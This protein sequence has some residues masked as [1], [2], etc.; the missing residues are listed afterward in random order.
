[1]ADYKFLIENMTFSF[2]RLSSYH[3]CPYQ[4]KLQYID[5]EDGIQNFFS[6]FGTLCHS[7]LERYLKGELEIYELS[8]TYEKEFKEAVSHKAPPNKYVD[9]NESYFQQGKDY[10]DTFEGLKYEIV[11]VEKEICINIDGIKFTGFIDALIK[12]KNGDYAIIDHKSSDPKSANSEKAKEYWKQMT[13]YSIGIFDEYGVYPKVLNINAFRKQQWFSKELEE[14][15]VEEAKKWVIDTVD[16]L[17]NEEDWLPKSDFYFC[18]WL[19]N[20]RNFCP[21]RPQGEKQ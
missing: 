1:M 2:S 6:D 20:F 9:L 15:S 12:D 16:K 17:M 13:L 11:A 21:Y 3:Q 10:F 5:C 14:T 7:I 19:C 4:F 8:A 18:N